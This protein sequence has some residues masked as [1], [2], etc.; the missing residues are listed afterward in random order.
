MK[1][2]EKLTNVDYSNDHVVSDANNATETGGYYTNAD[3]TNLPMSGSAG[4]LNVMKRNDDNINQI[5]TRYRD[6]QVFMR[7]KNTIEPSGWKEWERLTTEPTVLYEN[8]NGSNGNIT[9][10]DDVDNYLAI[11]IFYKGDNYSNFNSTKILSPFGNAS[12]IIANINTSGQYMG[13]FFRL[14]NVSVSN[15]QIN[16]NENGQLFSNGFNVNNG[17][18]NNFIYITKVLGYK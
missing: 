2:N 18:T 1:L 3:T 14:S 16:V 13:V 15:N 4:Y 8:S 6:N 17:T 7:Q 9:L 5:W 12:L 10:S 11:E